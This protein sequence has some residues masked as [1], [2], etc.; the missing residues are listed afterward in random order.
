VARALKKHGLVGELI[1]GSSRFFDFFLVDWREEWEK[2]ILG[3]C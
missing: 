2:P 3:K 1:N